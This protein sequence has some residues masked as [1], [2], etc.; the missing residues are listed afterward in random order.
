MNDRETGLALVIVLWILSLL[1]IM[2]GSFALTMRRETT[3][4]SAVKD[5]A[6]ILAAAESGLVI[7]WQMMT[8]ADE[9][10]RW[11]ADGSIYQ[12]FYREAE[13][14]VRI[15]SEQGKID[16]NKADEAMLRTLLQATD[17]E[18]EQQQAI[19]SAIID[20]RDEDDLVYIN[21]AEKEEYQAAGL[22]YAPA[23][24]AFALLDELQLVLGMDS[25]LYRQLQPLATVY[26]EQ[27]GVNLQLAPKEVLQA[28][29]VFDEATLNDYLWARRENA[30]LQLPA[31]PLPLEEDGEAG[32]GDGGDVYT[33]IAQARYRDVGNAGIQAII[34]KVNDANSSVYEVL[35]WRQTYGNASLFSADM[36][37]LLVTL[38]DESGQQY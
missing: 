36:E 12:A 31:P 3:V 14:R 10:M 32:Q 33:V 34:R 29:A 13:I 30:R 5:N 37:Q 27:S 24:K 38:Q 16:I 23:N 8:L 17:A 2:A 35:D 28:L 26:S 4:I 22:K 11:R 18:P 1:I 25:S 7:A 21:G 19:V 20:W 9:N 6:E 15:V